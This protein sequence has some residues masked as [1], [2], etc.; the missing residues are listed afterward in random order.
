MSVRLYFTNATT[1]YTPTTKR[2]AWDDSAGTTIKKLG[3]APS[4]AAATVAVAETSTTNNYD[5]L[6][7]RWVS[8]PI[9]NAKTISGNVSWVIGLK[10]SNA[11][12]NMMVHVHVYVTTGDSDTVRGTLLADS[13]GTTELPTTAAGTT[14]GTKA[15]TSTA[16]SVGDRI[17][18]E[19]GYQSQNTSATSY[20]GT[21]N[22]GNTGTNDLAAAATTVTTRPGYIE[23]DTEGLFTNKMHTL[24]DDF[25]DN[26]LSTAKWYKD[27]FNS[28]ISETSNQLQL[29]N[30][31]A[32][33]SYSYLYSSDGGGLTG[34]YSLYGS[35]AFVKVVD[36][37]SQPTGYELYVLE[38]CKNSAN[39]V[40]WLI[41]GGYIQAYKK[42]NG[43]YTNLGTNAVYSA[44]SHV[45]FRI[46]ESAGTIYWD[47]SADGI[48]WTNH[49]TL[50][51]PWPLDTIYASIA[52]GN[53]Q[54]LGATVLAKVDD[55]NVLTTTKTQTGKANIAAG[56]TITSRTQ[57]GVAR[58]TK[59]TGQTQTGVSRIQKTVTQTQTGKSRITKVVP[60][61]Q[62]GKGRVTVTVPRTQTG[63]SRVTATTT[64]TQTGKGNI[65]ITG[66]TQRPITGVSRV[67][68]PVQQAQTGKASIKA[69][70]TRTQTGKGRVT[71]VT[72]RNQTGKGNIKA[73]VQ[74]TTTGTATI[75]SGVIASNKP[76]GFNYEKFNA[77]QF[78]SRDY[79][80]SSITAT[81]RNQTGKGA[82]LNTVGA[83]IFHDSFDDGLTGALWNNSFGSNI[84]ETGGAVQ[85][86]SSL[87]PA[88]YWQ[89][90]AIGYDFTRGVVTSRIGVVGGQS[91]VSYEFIP[92][93]VT[94]DSNN[95]HYISISNSQIRGVSNVGG[96]KTVGAAIAYTSAIKYV[97]IRELLGTVYFEYST[98]GFEWNLLSSYAAS[99][100]L[101]DVL[102]E[103]VAGTWSSESSTAV[104]SVDE[105]WLGRDVANHQPGVSRI[106]RSTTKTQTGT[107][108][109][110]LTSS[111]TRSQTGKGFI[112]APTTRT[113]TGKAYIAEQTVFVGKRFEY[114][115]YDSDG[116][117]I[118]AWQD[119]ISDFSYSQEINSAGSDVEIILARPADN[120]GENVSVKFNNEVKVYVYDQD[121]PSGLLHSCIWSK[122][123]RKS[124]AHG[125]WLGA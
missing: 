103:M 31:T 91:L 98:N 45:Y 59:T 6:L 16:V 20:T 53:Y 4:G 15:V 78:N 10:E 58:I 17:V 8:D 123:T 105:I 121:T 41:S 109:I 125:L 48:T 111:T 122:R 106:T 44:A 29:L 1:G 42:I 65:I 85:I 116:N 120:F 3:L 9:V 47:Y 63:V 34:Y 80:G 79:S 70:T 22:Y 5:V 81:P 87:T 66:T 12:A 97:R 52:T 37:P 107:A 18:V 7:G 56:D 84:T 108:N 117:Y 113:Q 32:V 27:E 40:N 38:L 112:K 95:S 60:Q 100:S 119:V 55:F 104:S 124:N 74:R 2:G 24:V 19:V 72:Q 102:I 101:I 30:A 23:F 94:L 61:T 73:P 114:K 14:E 39:T 51:N 83:M 26:S 118:E 75:T 115:V 92:V 36:V 99:F 28:T 90:T 82:V 93:Q 110:T 88:Y 89:S 11:A 71:N 33:D 21:M 25:N 96:V 67:T 86:T 13:V 46:R 43:T 54:V 76:G 35:G 68:K 49:T 69:T 62:T 77:Y 57:T 50:A 64:R